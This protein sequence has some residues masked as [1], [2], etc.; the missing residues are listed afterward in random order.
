MK[1]EPNR[2]A[3]RMRRRGRRRLAAPCAGGCGRTARRLI[4]VREVTR[5]VDG[6]GRTVA[7]ESSV[8]VLMVPYCWT[9]TPAS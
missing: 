8:R 5:E 2:A 4:R 7:G 6:D 1:P 9:C 3:R